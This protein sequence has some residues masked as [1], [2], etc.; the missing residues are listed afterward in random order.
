MVAYASGEYG[1]NLGVGRKTRGEQD[2]RNEYE[3]RA[4]HI[5]E[6]RYEVEVVV[7]DDGV[8]RSF[9]LDEVV[10]FFRDVEDD[11]YA[12]DENQRHEE[13]HH[14]PLENV[15]VEFLYH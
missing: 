11:D 6:I 5:D 12:D 7:K 13:G 14:K 1:D 4:E 9:V 8:Q 3:Q 15:P 10:Y 2:Y